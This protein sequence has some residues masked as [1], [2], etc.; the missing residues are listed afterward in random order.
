MTIEVDCYVFPLGSV[1]IILRVA[2][3]ETL[4]EVRSNWAEPT[5]KFKQRGD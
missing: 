1:D 2:W 3:L 5:M 4:G